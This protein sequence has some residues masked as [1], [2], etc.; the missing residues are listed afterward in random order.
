MRSMYKRYLSRLPP[1]L[2]ATVETAEAL[3]GCEVVI[4]S[5]E[6]AA[7]FDNLGLGLDQRTGDCDATIAHRGEQ[8]S[9]WALVHEV[10]HLGEK[11]VDSMPFLLPN[12]ER[13]RFEA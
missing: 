10:L 2:Q 3:A 11:W 8:L 13:Y 4:A 5:N 1:E 7:D 12:A 6:S 9:Q